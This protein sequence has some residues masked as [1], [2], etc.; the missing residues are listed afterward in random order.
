[1]FAD[2]ME[3]RALGSCFL[4]VGSGM[5][6]KPTEYFVVVE[7]FEV[8]PGITLLGHSAK[9]ETPWPEA[10][11]VVEMV[12]LDGGRTRVKILGVDQSMNEIPGANPLVRLVW[13]ARDSV[14]NLSLEGF[15][16]RPVFGPVGR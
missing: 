15:R 2:S 10:G 16:V 9:V 13:I 8:K 14:K 11:E 7:V 6:P 1:M 12:G 4:W 5:S 3:G